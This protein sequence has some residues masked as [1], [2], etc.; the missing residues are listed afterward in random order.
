VSDNN[1]YPIAAATPT[2][3]A[4]TLPLPS[5]VND[6]D[7]S[8]RTQLV[9]DMEPAWT[10]IEVCVGG[11]AALRARSRDFIPREPREDEAAY[12]RRIFHAT[13]PPFL[14]RLASQAAGVILRKGIEIDGD[15]YWTD[16][17]TNVT[18]DGTTLNEYA[19]RQLITAILFG[20]SSSIVDY[21]ADSTAQSLAE[22]RALARRPYLVPIHP[23]Q[24]LGWRT[25]NDSWS[26]DLSQV[27]IR[28]TVILS[29]GLYGEEITEQIRVLSPGRYELWR[30]QTP[31]TNLPINNQLPGPT[32]WDLYKPGT[33][34]LDRIPLVTVYSNRTGNLL[35][36]PPLLEVAQLNIAYAQRFCD[37]HHSI[38]VG[39]CPILTFY[40]LDEEQLENGEAGLSVNNAILLPIGG[41]AKYVE[42]T[43][44]A[45]DAQLK[46][47]AALEDQISRLGINTL[48]QQNVTN[49]AAESKRMDRI[50]SDSIMA[51][52]AGDL[53]RSITEIFELAA[54]YTDIEPPTISIPRDY[55]NRLLDGNQITAYLQLYMQR[56]IS[57]RTLLTIL[58]QG[59]VLPPTIDIDA[60]ISAVQELLEE[61][62]AMDRLSASADGPDLAFQSSAG[63]PDVP[64]RRNAGQGESPA[65]QTLPTPMRPGRNVD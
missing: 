52:I 54:A 3:P 23:R 20:H 53:E 16:W 55:E 40:G 51:V 15:P 47:L 33:T 64:A 48:T 32:A 13:L 21:P 19:R 41:D 10:P 11:T 31:R 65:S 50:D 28:E 34:S 42:P 35:S 38:H 4:Y 56:A 60:E 44:D 58:Q 36:K 12:N 24:I 49:A 29:A 27:R 39:A 43:S 22:E 59:E 7:P 18:G 9:Q 46:C 57:Q 8:K 2:Q 61:Q 25:S 37:Y 63:A 14:T 45:F 1:S 26:S 30:P 17:A 6:T 62:L 5:G